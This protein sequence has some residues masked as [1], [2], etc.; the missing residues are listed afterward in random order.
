MKGHA[1]TLTID[2]DGRDEGFSGGWTIAIFASR[3]AAE[4][5]RAEIEGWVKAINAA[6][7]GTERA[8]PEAQKLVDKYPRAF[9]IFG[10]I[11]LHHVRYTEFNIEYFPYYRRKFLGLF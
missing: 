5:A 2:C 11:G 8:T 4:N 9:G 3:R 1:Y 10:S 6:P 7:R